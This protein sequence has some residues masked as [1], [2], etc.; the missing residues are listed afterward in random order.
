MK[1]AG[2]TGFEGLVAQMGEAFNKAQSLEDD[3]K[4]GAAAADSGDS[5]AAGVGDG[6]TGGDAGDAGASGSA[7]AGAGEGEGGAAAGADDG[8]GAGAGEG[9]EGEGEGDDFAKSFGGDGNEFEFELAD[10]SKVKAFN[11]EAMLKSFGEKM[12]TITAGA[13]EGLSAALAVIN[14]QNEVI[15]KQGLMLK[16]LQADVTRLANSG[17]GRKSITSLP[18]QSAETPLAK[19]LQGDASPAEMLAKCLSAQAAGKISAFDSSR[20]NIAV[21]MGL[22]IPAEIVARLA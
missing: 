14:K 5:G 4:I 2:E 12:Q 3:A 6:S 21:E 16:S 9:G 1:V 19:S 20:A 17:S 7:D 13:Q 22:P 18:N 8:A 15:E 11:G 10:G